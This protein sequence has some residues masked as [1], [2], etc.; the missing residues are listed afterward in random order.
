MKILVIAD[1]EEKNL[2]DYWSEETAVSLS[3]VELILSA[4]DLD[5]E[6]LEFLVSMLN[7]PLVYIHGNHDETYQERPPE[8]CIDAD[9][10]MLDIKCA[11]G[12]VRI[13]GLGGSM[14]YK[15]DSPYMF[16]EKD[17]QSRMKA[18]KWTVRKDRI[19]GRL[20]GGKSLDILL[21]HAP[22]KGYGDLPD[23]PHQGFNCFNELL[24]R[25]HPGLHVYGHIHREY[26]RSDSGLDGI[27][28]SA[29]GFRR[30]AVHPSGTTLVN[31]KGFSVLDYPII[32]RFIH[33]R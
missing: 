19:K 24:N 31:A 3:D 9:G 22:C 27:R 30:M 25:Q 29:A 12:T 32:D 13:L 15:D 1:H 23:L 2:W 18:L 21:T 6:Y 33:H 16:S 20:K 10:R 11:H 4:G 26:G 5:A 8:G 17:M 14:R 28:R 7:I